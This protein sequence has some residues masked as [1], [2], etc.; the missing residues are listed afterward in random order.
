MMVRRMV[1]VVVVGCTS[2][3]LMMCIAYRNSSNN[4]IAL[5]TYRYF[6]FLLFSLTIKIAKS[7]CTR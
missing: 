3:V 5:Y 4:L 1:L 6:L 7:A 2:Y